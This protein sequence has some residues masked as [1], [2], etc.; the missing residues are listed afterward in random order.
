M[1]PERIRLNHPLI[2]G[3]NSI[4]AQTE[5]HGPYSLEAESHDRGA[6]GFGLATS[7][8]R[9]IC[10]AKDLRRD[11]PVVRNQLHHF[12]DFDFLRRQSQDVEQRHQDCRS[13]GNRVELLDFCLQSCL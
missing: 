9:R 12:F 6:H 4:H 5:Q 11:R 7:E 8:E 1:P 2:F 3:D 10:Q 13:G